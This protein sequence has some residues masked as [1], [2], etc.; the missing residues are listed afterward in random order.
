MENLIKLKE[1][2]KKEMD[3]YAQNIR[4]HISKYG[5]APCDYLLHRL[6]MESY[7]RGAWNALNEFEREL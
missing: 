3:M 4:D 6:R 1:K 7:H 2:H 5:E